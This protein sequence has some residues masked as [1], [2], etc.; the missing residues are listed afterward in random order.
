[1][2][3]KIHTIERSSPSLVSYISIITSYVHSSASSPADPLQK[4][5]LLQAKSA[6]RV[7]RTDQFD[8]SRSTAGY[9][10]MSA[11]CV[12]SDQIMVAVDSLNYSIN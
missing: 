3:A 8:T 6:S 4:N 9:S 11:I 12:D 2:S 7:R 1:M 10:P 5:W